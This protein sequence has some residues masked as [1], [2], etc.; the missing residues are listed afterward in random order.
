M[1]TAGCVM[2][3][4]LLLLF[5]TFSKRLYIGPAACAAYQPAPGQFR[6]FA[7]FHPLFNKYAIPAPGKAFLV[8]KLFEDVLGVLSGAFVLS[9]DGTVTAK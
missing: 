5:T 2:A 1:L 8:G 6:P 9:H 4:R 3:K 7:L